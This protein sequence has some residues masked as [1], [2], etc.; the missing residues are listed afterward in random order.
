M[1]NPKIL[2]DT[3]IIIDYIRK[4]NKENSDLYKYFENDYQIY[5]SSITTFEIYTGLNEVN[6]KLINIIFKKFHEINFD[7]SIAKNASTIYNDLKKQNQIIEIR[8]IFIAASAIQYKLPIA[9]K[10]LKHFSRIK[11]LNIAEKF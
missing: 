8:D 7:N 9:T 1:G 4:I 11:N 6:K 5:I 3:S 2:I 10:N